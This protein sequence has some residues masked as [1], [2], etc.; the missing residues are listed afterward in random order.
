MSSL[1]QHIAEVRRLLGANQL[2]QAA[3]RIPDLLAQA[4][5]DPDVLLAAGGVA[6]FAANYAECARHYRRLCDV[7]PGTP[8]HWLMLG[9]ALEYVSTSQE[10]L[11][12]YDSGLRL[13]PDDIRLLAGKAS[14]LQRDGRRAEARE[15][16]APHMKGSAVPAE[17]ALIY[18]T[19]A[20]DHEKSPQIVEFLK[21]FADAADA[22]AYTRFRIRLQLGRM[23][24]D[25]ERYEEAFAEY[26]RGNQ[27]GRTM[28]PFDPAPFVNRMRLFKRFF[29]RERLPSLPRAQTTSDRH[30][31]VAGMPR[32]GT[33]LIDQIIHIHPNGFGVGERPEVPQLFTRFVTSNA[34]KPYPD[35][36]A[37]L[38]PQQLTEAA[39]TYSA[40]VAKDAGDARRILDKSLSN[41]SLLGFIWMLL[42]GARIIWSR[43]DPMDTCFSC[44]TSPLRPQVHP[45]ACD[46]AAAGLAFRV[47]ERL[48][49]HW[50]STLDMPMFEFEYEATVADP[51]TRIRSLIDFCGLPWNDRCL[52]PH[53]SDGI[54]RTVS[55]D[56]VRKP[57]ND[58]SIGRWKK[59][60]KWLEPLKQSL[61]EN[62][63]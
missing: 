6:F 11:D 19:L 34:G 50:Q 44:F 5:D 8:T 7:A 27:I 41:I 56:Q 39:D 55:Q 33:T 26:S 28:A 3:A 32:S 62:A 1:A 22:T 24:E 40:A 59:F 21:P 17:A 47:Q 45:Y 10:C 38:S 14:T 42:P 23:L 43:R 60:E 49:Q 29:T 30:L 48:M 31:L 25:L 52:R 51:D 16:L 2:S 58:K 18:A 13:A 57:I 36:L 20:H 35:F 12:A 54:V 46:L 9:R 61:A 15:L 4:P 63:G 37:D 53:E